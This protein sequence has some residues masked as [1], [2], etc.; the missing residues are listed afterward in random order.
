MSNNGKERG[1]IG[2]SVDRGHRPFRN[3]NSK[4]YVSVEMYK[5][6]VYPPFVHGPD[7]VVSVSLV[8]ALTQAVAKVAFL[9]LED[10]YL[11]TLAEAAGAPLCDPGGVHIYSV[12][13]WADLQ[14]VNNA[15]Y[16]GPESML[17]LWQSCITNNGTWCS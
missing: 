2:G 12:G 15:H 4:W 8:P 7:Y 11:G 14:N 13:G 10:V 17:S 5:R 16:M 1:F 9:Y 3:Q 6:D